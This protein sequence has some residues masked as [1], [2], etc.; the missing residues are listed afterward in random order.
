ML[1]GVLRAV[2]V[3]GLRIP[4]DISVVGS[5]D[6]DLADLYAPPISVQRWDQAEVGRTAAGLLLDRILKRAGQEPRHV[7]LPNEFVARES[8]GPAPAL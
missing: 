8:T 4:A 3:R 6:S 7:L 5:G 1:P 2:R